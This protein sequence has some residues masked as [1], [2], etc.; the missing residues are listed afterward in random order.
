M[1]SNTG[2][3]SQY[4]RTKGA[5]VGLFAGAS[6]TKTASLT[7]LIEMQGEFMDKLPDLILKTYGSSHNITKCDIFFIG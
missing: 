7:E 5:L 2:L 6:V 1:L 3:Q 4:L